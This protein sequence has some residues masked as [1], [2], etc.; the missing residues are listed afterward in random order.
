MENKGKIKPSRPQTKVI[1]SHVGDE[2]FTEYVEDY[3]EHNG[4]KFE[5]AFLA[6][7]PDTIIFVIF[8]SSEEENIAI[9]GFFTSIPDPGYPL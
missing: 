9:Y 5:K 8:D 7:D 2:A 6:D 3:L 1:Y 4:K